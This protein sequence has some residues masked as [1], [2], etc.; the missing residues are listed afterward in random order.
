[1]KLTFSGTHGC[2]LEWSPVSMQEQ[3]RGKRGATEVVQ[4]LE[5]E[6]LGAHVVYDECNHEI[7]VTEIA[8]APP[9]FKKRIQLAFQK[10]TS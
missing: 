9:K 4:A 8:P 10:C 5:E 3:A 6:L 7:R 2:T 1:M